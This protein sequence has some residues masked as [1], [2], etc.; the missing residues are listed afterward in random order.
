[1]TFL[2]LFDFHHFLI[3]VDD[4]LALQKNKFSFFGLK[5]TLFCWG[6]FL[7]FRSTPTSY[8]LVPKIARR[9]LFKNDKIGTKWVTQ[10][11]FVAMAKMPFFGP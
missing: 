7:G 11:F 9:D 4:F 2:I 6:P 10:Q 5:G 8:R 3:M 1:M